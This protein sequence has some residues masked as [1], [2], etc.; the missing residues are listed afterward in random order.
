MVRVSNTELNHFTLDNIDI[1]TYH[2]YNPPQE[3][4]QAIDTLKRY[5]RPVI[6][7]EYMARPFGSTFHSLADAFISYLK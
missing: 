4:Q 2:T 1:L 5:G 7:T 6:C 3:H